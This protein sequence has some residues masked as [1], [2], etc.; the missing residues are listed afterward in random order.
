MRKLKVIRS[1]YSSS[2]N[3]FTRV[4]AP[5]IILFG[6]HFHFFSCLFFSFRLLWKMTI[7]IIISIQQNVNDKQSDGCLPPL[8]AIFIYV[9]R[10]RIDGEFKRLYLFPTGAN[11]G[12]RWRRKTFFLVRF[13]LINVFFLFFFRSLFPDTSSTVALSPTIKCV[14][15]KN[16]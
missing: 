10:L 12:S 1:P 7:M 15:N 8:F 3:F 14:N 2:S 4:L 6:F 16:M 5:G 13:F 11:P 9:Y